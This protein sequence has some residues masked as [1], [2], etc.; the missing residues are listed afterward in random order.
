MFRFKSLVQTGVRRGSLYE[1]KL[2]YLINN[3][4]KESAATEYVPVR[5]PATQVNTHILLIIHSCLYIH[6]GSRRR[7]SIDAGRGDERCCRCC[8]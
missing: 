3:E 7:S 2:K 1:G 6:V 8:C 5:N 4:W